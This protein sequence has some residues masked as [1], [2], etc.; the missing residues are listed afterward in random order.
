MASTPGAARAYA[1]LNRLC[2]ALFTLS[3]QSLSPSRL[4]LSRSSSLIQKRPVFTRVLPDVLPVEGTPMEKVVIF[5]GFAFG[6]VSGYVGQH[7]VVRVV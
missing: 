7:D 2:T 1:R 5:E 3:P 4:A 6:T